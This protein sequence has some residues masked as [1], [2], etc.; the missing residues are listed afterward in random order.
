MVRR[1]GNG[2]EIEK[3]PAVVEKAE[4]DIYLG[5]WKEVLQEFSIEV[6]MH[7]FPSLGTSKPLAVGLDD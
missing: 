6:L 3:S 7:A 2:E 1:L 5:V 4:E